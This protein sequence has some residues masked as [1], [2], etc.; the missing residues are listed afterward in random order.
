MLPYSLEDAA[1]FLY[2]IFFLLKNQKFCVT[3]SKDMG[4]TKFPPVKNINKQ[5]KL[6]ALFIFL[7]T[8][9][10]KYVCNLFIYYLEA[11]SRLFLLQ[12]MALYFIYLGNTDI[13]PMLHFYM[14]INLRF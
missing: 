13:P 3:L 7:F 1:S 6:R 4:H 2:S 14:C 10:K 9:V 5:L 8:M 12:C 11:N